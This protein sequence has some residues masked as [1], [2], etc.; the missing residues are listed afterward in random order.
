MSV[1]NQ[2]GE[3]TNVH[4]GVVVAPPAGVIARRGAVTMKPTATH[5]LVTGGVALR[6]V[7]TPKNLNMVPLLI[8]RA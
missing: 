8:F 7:L 5:A 2:S 6:S 1:F 4:S 3:L